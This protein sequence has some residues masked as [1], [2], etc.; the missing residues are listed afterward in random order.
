M[1]LNRM[2][3][4]VVVV[5][6]LAGCATF[7]AEVSHR[8]QGTQAGSRQYVGGTTLSCAGRARIGAVTALG[9]GWVAGSIGGLLQIAAN[10]STDKNAAS[11]L[12][13]FGLVLDVAGFVGE[14]IGFVSLGNSFAY[15]V[16]AGQ[17]F[18]GY[19]D[20][21]CDQEAPQVRNRCTDR[22]LIAS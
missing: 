7:N 2:G 5:L 4:V 17:V 20:L 21:G 18:S 9:L 14:V 6:S 3:V 13:T 16:R 19:S 11:G 8:A 1:H 12:S 15:E 22:C 10:T